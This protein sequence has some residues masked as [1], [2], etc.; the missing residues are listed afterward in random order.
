ML[1]LR[2]ISFTDALELI[3]SECGHHRERWM[4]DQRYSPKWFLCTL[5]SKEFQDLLVFDG[6]KPASRWQE[7][8]DG[9]YEIGKVAVGLRNYSDNDAELLRWRDWVLAYEKRMGAN[10]FPQAYCLVRVGEGG[11][12]TLFET[13]RRALALYLHC[14]AEKKSAYEPVKGILAQVRTKLPQQSQ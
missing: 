6:G 2:P 8:A 4:D 10:E 9:S 3:V 13:N 11:R 14:F 7:F 12:I 1:N 5:E